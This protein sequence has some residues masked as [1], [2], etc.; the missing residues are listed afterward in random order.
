MPSKTTTSRPGIRHRYLFPFASTSR[1]LPSFPLCRGR[2]Y[3]IELDGVST[4]QFCLLLLTV[5]TQSACTQ[6]RFA[7]CLAMRI[8][9]I[10]RSYALHCSSVDRFRIRSVHRFT[11]EIHC[12][13]RDDSS[14][15]ILEEFQI[16][17]FLFFSDKI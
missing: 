15:C 7:S 2:Y 13:R 12:Y 1:P 11:L 8:R 14:F 4:R 3:E 16:Y 6:G 5:G 17:F 9:F 10:I